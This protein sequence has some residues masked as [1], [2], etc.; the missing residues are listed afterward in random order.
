MHLLMRRASGA[1]DE[2][3]IA[4][5]RLLARARHPN[6]V[7][8]Y[9][10]ERIADAWASGWSCSKVRLDRLPRHGR[11]AR[12]ARGGVDWRRPLRR[13]LAALVWL[14]SPGRHLAANVMRA[15][16][17]RIVLVDFGLG[18]ESAGAEGSEES[19]SLRGTPLFMVPE[20]L[21]GARA[22]ARSDLYSLGVILFALASGALPL[23]ATTLAELRESHRRGAIR[24]LRDVRPDVEAPFAEIVTRLL[25][26][27]RE[28]RFQTAGQLERAL[29]G[30]ECTDSALEPA[31]ARPQTL[32][33]DWPRSG[34]RFVGRDAL[35]ADLGLGGG[36]RPV[37][38]LGARS[39]QD[40]TRHALWLEEPRDWPGVVR[41][42]DRSTRCA[43]CRWR[44]PVRCAFHSARVI[45][46]SA[47]PRRGGARPLP[48]HPRQLR[49]GGGLRPG[50]RRELAHRLLR[51][52]PPRDQSR[53]AQAERRAGLAGSNRFPSTRA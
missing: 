34:D 6:V 5:A 43:G 32:P 26:A 13:A 47:W 3:T 45:D 29:L 9:G 2:E 31:N 28:M 30:F 35:L 10:A 11:C 39:G 7:L 17:G 12:R 15:V 4:E 25:S 20:V 21:E 1:A 41:R 40:P 33:I 27:D 36:A 37:T 49:T 46:L 8:V 42:P 38:L 51:T 52:S 16:G 50:H 48:G 53:A 14:G 23:Q 24:P 19:G 18:A 22:D 44:W